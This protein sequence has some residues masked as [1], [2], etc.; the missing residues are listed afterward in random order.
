MQARLESC[1]SSSGVF[2]LVKLEYHSSTGLA[3][4][5]SLFPE[6]FPYPLSDMGSH[7]SYVLK[8]TSDGCILH[9]KTDKNQ[10]ARASATQSKIH[11][12]GFADKD[13]ILG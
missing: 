8:F 4:K 6:A 3:F 13:F 11:K 1:F 12:G 5:L 10:E 7:P 2:H 9:G